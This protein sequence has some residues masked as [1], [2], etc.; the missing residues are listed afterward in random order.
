MAGAV[1]D[2]L[3]EDR[4]PARIMLHG[5][6][7][8]SAAIFPGVSA[9]SRVVR[10]II[11]IASSR[12]N[13]FASRLIDRF[14]DALTRLAV[15]RRRAIF[16]GAAA[17]ALLSLLAA[18]SGSVAIDW[19]R[20]PGAELVLALDGLVVPGGEST[21]FMRLMRLYGLDEAV[22][23][24]AVP[25][26]GTCA[27]TI[28]PDRAH[29]D[30]VDIVLDRHTLGF[31]GEQDPPNIAGTNKRNRKLD[32]L[33]GKCSETVQGT[34]RNE[35]QNSFRSVLGEADWKIS[36]DPADRR[37]ADASHTDQAD[38]QIRLIS[39]TP[40]IRGRICGAAIS[41]HRARQTARIVV[42]TPR[43]SHARCLG[44]SQWA[45]THYKY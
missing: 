15:S 17:L 2:P 6:P 9:P 21:T 19:D 42:A 3:L 45:L 4:P 34:V 26:L 29:L 18:L 20:R 13:S 1:D 8:P 5:K 39:A 14:A 32:E 41:M 43:S 40:P 16:W 12:A 28:L 35:L 44:E 11:R 30:Q 36:E 24:F 33:V 38:P 31:V 27:G 25:V 7:A 23:G 37:G 22:R 10:S